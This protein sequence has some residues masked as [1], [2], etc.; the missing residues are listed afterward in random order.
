ME[1]VFKD[2]AAEGK[3]IVWFLIMSLLI[4]N[5]LGNRVL[6]GFLALVFA[7]MLITNANKLELYLKKVVE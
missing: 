5:F 1:D 3:F 4:G 7:G 6:Y 2:I